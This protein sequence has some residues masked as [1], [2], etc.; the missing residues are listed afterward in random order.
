[1]SRNN[2][3]NIVEDFEA[4]LC[5]YTGAP[6]AV[7]TNSCTMAIFL[8]CAWHRTLA[9]NIKILEIPKRTYVSV[10]MSI[11]HAGYR[12]SFREENWSGSYQLKPLPIYDSARRFSRNMYVPTQYQCVSFHASKILG[13][14]QG[15]AILCDDSSANAWFRRA[16]FDGRSKGVPPKDDYFN[17]LGWHCYMSPDVAAALLLKFYS[18]PDENKDLP[19]DSYPDLSTFRIFYDR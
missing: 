10:P 11:I 14:S 13:H 19:N 12:V 1:M 7:T 6:Y 18:L 5:E 3:Y 4:A 2:P 17:M 16:R 9:D 15:G 8:T